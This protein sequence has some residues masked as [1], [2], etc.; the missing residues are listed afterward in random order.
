MRHISAP[1][2]T[3]VA[4]LLIAT[5]ASAQ[6]QSPIYTEVENEALTVPALNVTVDN[7][8]DMDVIDPNGDTIGEIDEVLADTDG[9]IAA[10]T[11]EAGGFLGIG[12]EEIVVP[13]DR[14]Q[15]AGDEVRIDMTQAEMEALP[16]WD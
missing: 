12:D 16:R 11:I 5:T 9:N 10:V 15:A 6:N 13:L 14:L 7:L 4:A 1:I 3:A 2:C 8:E